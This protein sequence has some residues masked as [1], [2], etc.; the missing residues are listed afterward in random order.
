[1]TGSIEAYHR[2]SSYSRYEMGQGGLDFGH[3]PDVFKQYPGLPTVPLPQVMTLPEDRLSTVIR[4]APK[5]KADSEID[6]NSLSKI[7]VLTHSLTAKARYGGTEFYYRSVASAGAL[8]PFELYVAVHNVPGLADGLY[9]H[10]VGLHSLTLLRADNLMPFVAG[11]LARGKESPPALVFFL[12]SIFFRSSWK[13]RERAYRYALLD[14]GHLAESLVLALRSMRLMFRVQYDFDDRKLNDLLAVD[15]RREVCLAV[16]SVWSESIREVS[17]G[18]DLKDPP[19]GLSSASR[20][21][22]REKDYPLIRNVHDATCE[23]L[24]TGQ[25]PPR[26][27]EHL[28]PQL[29]AAAKAPVTKQWPEVMKYSDAIFKRRSNRNF[30]WSSL[31]GDVLG[32]L[33]ESLVAI[34]TERV[35]A[36]RMGCDSVSIGLVAGNVEGLDAGFYL[37]D[38]RNQTIHLASA[39]SFIDRMAH[40]CLDQG[41][42]SNCAAHFLFVCNLESLE[43][44]WGPRGYRYAML[45]AGRLGQRLYL[46]ATSM[47]VGCCGIGAFY[48][49]EA[50]DL[51][52]LNEHSALLY[53][54]ATGPLKKWTNLKE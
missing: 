3:Q 6:V 44:T 47:R 40:V 26:M 54:V 35:C 52:G 2:E 39:A 29:G 45:T 53:L 20:V 7:L 41:W 49:R 22:A 36:D 9:H 8:Y 18:T 28:G 14:T 16:A 4:E 24:I 21:S 17:V 50:A 10:S 30:V 43:Q 25:D 27:V 19:T 1:M 42:L 5:T 48:D 33:L 15:Q 34:R 38:T 46:A 37:L 31:S 12:T 13:Y 11:C 51:L 23:A 32:A